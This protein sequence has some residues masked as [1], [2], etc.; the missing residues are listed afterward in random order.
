MADDRFSFIHQPYALDVAGLD[1]SVDDSESWQ[2]PLDD[3]HVP[4]HLLPPFQDEDDETLL[5]SQTHPSYPYG[6]P[7]RFTS[8]SLLHSTSTR[9][10]SDRPTTTGN[11]HSTTTGSK[12][13]GPNLSTRLSTFELGHLYSLTRFG[14]GS[15]REWQEM[16]LP[17]LMGPL[18]RAEQEEDLEQFEKHVMTHGDAG[19]PAG[20]NAADD[21][22]DEDD[23][24]DDDDDL[25]DSLDEDGNRAE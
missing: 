24:E 10:S 20:Q 23:E 5:P 9:S 7:Y 14:L 11:P 18:T 25:G 3:I 15:E 12:T 19:P 6:N 16:G 13:H 21:D 8:T 2:L 22:D 1:S 17:G 4:D